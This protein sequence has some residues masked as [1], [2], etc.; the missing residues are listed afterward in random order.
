MDPDSELYNKEFDLRTF[1]EQGFSVGEG[2]L[3]L[4]SLKH[5]GKTWA[6]L[7]TACICTVMLG[8]A[9]TAIDIGRPDLARCI[10]CFQG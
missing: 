7:H 1:S 5:R 2:S 8:V 6:T 3:N 10:K 9:K 4:D